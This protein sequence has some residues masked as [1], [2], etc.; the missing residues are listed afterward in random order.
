M[1][2]FG[3]WFA[4]MMRG[5]YG[6][7]NLN[8]FLLIAALILMIAEVFIKW[9]PLYLL[10][11]LILIYVYC[12]MFSRN[13]NARYRENQKFLQLTAKL[14][15]NRRGGTYYGGGSYG[16]SSYGSSSYG[17]SSYGGA[18]GNNGSGFGGNRRAKTAKDR[19][20]RILKCPVCGEKLRVPKGAGKINITCPYCGEKFIKKV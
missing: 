12:R 17:G 9:R 15:K 6:T 1:N 13:I 3:M 14:R 8:R 5:R 16:N 18:Y 7:D 11:V 10:A 4:N 20:H 19:T 2:R